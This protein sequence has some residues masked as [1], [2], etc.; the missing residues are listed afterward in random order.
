LE[1]TFWT[2]IETTEFTTFPVTLDLHFATVWALEFC[3]FWSRRNW[4]SAACAGYQR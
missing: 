2:F 3:W 4:F 1:T